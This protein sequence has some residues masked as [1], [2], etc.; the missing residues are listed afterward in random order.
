MAAAWIYIEQLGMNLTLLKED[1]SPAGLTDW[2]T[3]KNL[4]AGKIAVFGD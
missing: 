3:I 2:M 4:L 1:I